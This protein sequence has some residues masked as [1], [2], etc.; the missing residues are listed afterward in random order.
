MNAEPPDGFAA[1]SK[2]VLAALVHDTAGVLLAPLAHA[3][4]DLSELFSGMA[5]SITEATH[6]E[7]VAFLEDRCGAHIRRHRVGEDIIGR[8]RRSAVEL[9]LEIGAQRVF[10]ADFDTVLRWSETDKAELREVL[11]RTDP[12]LIVGRDAGAF[13][14]LPQRLQRTE[15]LVNHIYALMTGQ[16]ADLLA[17]I[18][19]MS[20]PAAR[21]IVEHAKEEGL[22]NDVEWPLLAARLGFA[23]TRVEVAGISYRTIEEYGAAA[24]SLDAEPLQWIRRIEFAAGQA[25]VL[26]QFLEGCRPS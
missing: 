25:Q 3:A 20:R 4:A 24:D 8:A 21:A 9:A 12:F 18:R 23:V 14:A 16:R 15:H 1:G 11:A 10:H 7:V 5:L 6:P 26:R 13:A 19:S 17:A 2:P 22:A